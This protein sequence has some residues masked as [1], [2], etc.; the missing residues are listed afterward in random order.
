MASHHHHH[1][2]DGGCH[3]H[4]NHNHRESIPHIPA[5]YATP[6]PCC[7]ADSSPS[8]PNLDHLLRLI[9]SYLQNQQQ[10]RET[11]CSCQTLSPIFN[12]VK[13]QGF[14]N[15]QQHQKKKN[16]QREYD[17]LLRKIDDLEFLLNRSESYSTLKDSAARVIQT[18]FRSHLVRR[19]VSLRQLKELASIKSSFLSLKSSVSGKTHFLFE[20]VSREA[21]DLLLQ[22]DSIQVWCSEDSL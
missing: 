21:T 14:V 5:N 16:V 1:H 22:L 10:Q 7:C 4:H 19:S 15:Q 13:R 12:A 2:H 9:A 20:A 3:R 6:P 18:H 11:Q 8:P 17:N